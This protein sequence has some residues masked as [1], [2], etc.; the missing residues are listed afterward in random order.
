M[1]YFYTVCKRWQSISLDTWKLKKH[2]DFASTFK[3]YN[4]KEEIVVAFLK[5]C[6]ENL[7]SLDISHKSHRITSEII[8]IIGEFKYV[9][10]GFLF[11]VKLHGYEILFFPFKSN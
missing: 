6:G 5:R 11:K 7:Q 4:F 3:K 9:C 8:Q 10:I 2:L 1:N